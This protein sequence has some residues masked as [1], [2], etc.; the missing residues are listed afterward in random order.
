MQKLAIVLAVGMLMAATVQ[1][2]MVN[3]TAM[4]TVVW[5]GIPEPPLSGVGAGEQVTM[6]FNVDSSNFVEGIPGD[7]RGYEIDHASFMLSFSGGV[8]QGL[9]SPFP[10][11][12]TP[13]FT[14]VEGFPVSDGFFVAISAVSPGGVPLEQEDYKFNLDLGYEGSTLTSLDILDALGVYDF[15]GL[16]RFGLTL[17]R[18]FPDNVVLE[19]DFAQMEISTP[20][21]VDNSTWGAVKDMFR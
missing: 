14:L 13:Y 8:T 1:A 6:S 20:V 21:P 4:G 17:W 10:G 7:T 18:V 2:E 19:M 3:V 5:N 15:T 9:L 16:T 11:G 12:Q